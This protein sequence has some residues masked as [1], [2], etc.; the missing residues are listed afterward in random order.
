MRKGGDAMRFMKKC[1]VTS[2][3]AFSTVFPMAAFAQLGN[4]PAGINIAKN[5]SQFTGLL[6]F[7]TG[8]CT[9]AQWFFAFVLLLA[10]FCF[11]YSAFLFMTAGGNE[12]KVSQ[13]RR[14]LI[15]G[16]VG[17]MV[18]MLSRAFLFIVADFVGG[19]LPANFF[20]SCSG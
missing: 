2:G 12:T 8:F 16:I 11:L 1:I 4:P 15:Y 7:W 14:F 17:V 3:V 6:P 19:T 10:I 18:A 13:S 9:I 5:G 20:T